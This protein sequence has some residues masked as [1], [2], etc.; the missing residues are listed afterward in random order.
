MILDHMGNTVAFARQREE[1]QKHIDEK[2]LARIEAHLG[3]SPREGE[4]EMMGK[5]LIHPN[6]NVTLCWDKTPI[7]KLVFGRGKVTVVEL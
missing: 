7:M 5:Q 4:V 3:R 1:L 6:G 2:I